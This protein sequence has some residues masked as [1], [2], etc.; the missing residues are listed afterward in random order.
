MKAESFRNFRSNMAHTNVI[1]IPR[2]R[3]P[4][5]GAT[6]A[7]FT[8]RLHGNAKIAKNSLYESSSLDVGSLLKRLLTHSKDKDSAVRFAAALRSFGA[9]Y[10]FGS[11]AVKFSASANE[12][13]R[14][15]TRRMSLAARV[16]AAI[17]GAG[18]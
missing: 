8:S 2:L 7:E 12:R 5:N 14:D 10:T 4:R 15:Q 3:P 1:K 9:A 17:V 13:K 11:S 6:H 16:L 18:K